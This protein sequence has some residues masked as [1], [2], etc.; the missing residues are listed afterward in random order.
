M[1]HQPLLRLAVGEVDQH[2]R[3]VLGQIRETGFQNRRVLARN[4]HR[5]TL[6]LFVNHPLDRFE[7]SCR[8]VLIRAGD[9]PLFA[10]RQL[11]EHIRNSVGNAVLR[12]GEHAQR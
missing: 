2:A 6:T 1:Q 11:Q 4:C 5:G 9:D 8:F 3:F 10:D 12:Q 7:L